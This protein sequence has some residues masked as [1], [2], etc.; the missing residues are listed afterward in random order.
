MEDLEWVTH[1]AFHAS[2]IIRH[3]AAADLAKKAQARLGDQFL[4]ALK[5]QLRGQFLNICENHNFFTNYIFLN[6]PGL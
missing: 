5:K 1:D 2:E 3:L 4:T 6:Y